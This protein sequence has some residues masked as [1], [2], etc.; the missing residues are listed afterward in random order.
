MNLIL[1]KHLFNAN[2]DIIYCP[3]PC[4]ISDSKT[5]INCR[6]Q[7]KTTTCTRNS[8]VLR[9]AHMNNEFYA[10]DSIKDSAKVTFFLAQMKHFT[11]KNNLNTYELFEIVI[12][13]KNNFLMLMS[14]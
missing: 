7:S 5:T 8:A 10:N 9:L 13:S 3:I 2:V 1:F 4:L 12:V 6:C 14:T 11:S